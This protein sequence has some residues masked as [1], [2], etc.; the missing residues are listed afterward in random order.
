MTKK[1]TA[2]KMKEADVV[3]EIIKKLNMLPHV[4]AYKHYSGGKFGLKGV[5]DI[6]CSFNGIFVSIEVKSPYLPPE[7]SPYQ[8]E[9]ADMVTESKGIALCVNSWRQVVDLLK[10]NEDQLT[11]IKKK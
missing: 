9:F 2:F 1:G 3:S 11:Q 7:Y 10:I 5:H 8:K 4:F 6:I